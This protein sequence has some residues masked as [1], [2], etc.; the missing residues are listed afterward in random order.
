MSKNTCSEVT[1]RQVRGLFNMLMENILGKKGSI[2]L[3]AFRRFL[4]KEN[5][6]NFKK[7]LR[8]KA[9]HFSISAHSSL[10]ELKALGISVFDGLES[11]ACNDRPIFYYP[12]KKEGEFD[13]V[14]VRLG[15]VISFDKI[16]V[17]GYDVIIKEAQK[18]GF[19]KLS[20]EAAFTVGVQAV[21]RMIK[22]QTEG[23]CCRDEYLICSDPILVL[24]TSSAENIARLP[25]VG[26]KMGS[27]PSGLA[28][29]YSIE[30]YTGPH[31]DKMPSPFKNPETILVFGWSD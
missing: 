22:L 15:D 24:D 23:D 26:T 8:V 10:S 1:L 31:H 30:P 13:V 21:S 18:L 16:G 29:M 19:E 25:Y 4:R 28:T 6:W 5:S 3:E 27:K 7:V 20:K 11:I 12:V 2:W 17:W 9:R 14:A